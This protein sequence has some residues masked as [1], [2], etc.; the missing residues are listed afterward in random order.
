MRRYWVSADGKKLLY[1]TADPESRYAIV[2]TDKKPE[3]KEE[4]YL[5]MQ[6]L[7]VPVD[8]KAEWR[9]I[10]R[11]AYRIHRD[12][13]YDA[14][15]HGLDWEATYQKYLPFLEHVGHR[16]DLNYLLAELSGELVVGHA[17][18]GQGDIPAPAKVNVGL[19]G[20]GLMRWS[21]VSTAFSAFTQG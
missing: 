6:A 7:E 9:Q 14:P 3:P 15:L 16:E 20:C 19:L 11:E 4:D 8:P 1:Q 12:Y 5:K 18:V 2:G 13:F 10:F 21:M 17:Y